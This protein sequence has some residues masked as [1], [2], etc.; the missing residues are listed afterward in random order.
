MV[1]MG[2]DRSS[3]LHTRAVFHGPQLDGAVGRG[4]GHALVHRRE[5]HAPH[6]PPVSPHGPEVGA[7]SST[8]QLGSGRGKVGR[9]RGKVERRGKVRRATHNEACWVHTPC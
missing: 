7:V 3:H 8:P 4:G 1:A 6:P 9:G 2:G 5:D